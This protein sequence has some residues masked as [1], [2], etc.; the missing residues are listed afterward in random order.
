M[1]N[2]P[3]S[4]DN[5]FS[6]SDIHKVKFYAMLKKILL[7]ALFM[8]ASFGFAQDWAE[9]MTGTNAN[10]Y[11]IQSRFNDYWKDKDITE[12]GKGYKAFKRWENFVE[13]RVYPS[14]DL[15]LLNLTAKNFQEWLAEYN[16][17]NPSAKF[18]QNS[19]MAS[20]TWTPIGPMGA[21]SGSA[22]GQ[23]LKSGRLNFITFHPTN[24]NIMW[25]GA[26]AGG[27]WKTTDGGTTWS[28][29]TDNLA[30]NGCSDL[31]IDPSNTNIMYL[32][33]GDGDAGDTRS[34]GVL[35]STDGGNTWNSTGLTFAVTSNNLIRRLIIHP[36]NPQ[37]LLAATNSGIYRTTNGGTSW[38]NV[39][40]A[41]CY[42]LEFQP[43]NPNIV[44][45]GGTTF[46]RSTDGGVTWTQISNGITTTGVNRMAVA[47]TSNDANYVYVLCS[48]SSNS[49]FYGLYRS[50]DAGVTF[51]LMATTPNLLGWASAGNDSGGQ[52][53]YDLCVA[54]SPLDKNEV[55]VGGV[56]VWRS[57]NGGSTWTLYGHWTGSGA[58]FTHADHHDLEYTPAGV[59]YNCNDGT[60]YRRTATTWVEICGLMNISQIY[61]IGLSSLTPNLWITGHQDNGT[62]TWNGTTYQARIGGDG[63][64]CF[65]DRTNNNNIFGETQNGGFR[66]S[67]NAGS[68]WSTVTTG[69]SGT[70]PW[71]TIWKQDPVVANRIYCGRQNMFVSND[72][73]STWTQIGT[74]PV[75]GNVREFAIAPTNNQIIY[76]VKSNAIMKTTDGG[77]TWSNITGTLST[78]L[79]FFNLCVS[80]TDANKV[81]VC[82]TNYSA[83]NKV[84]YSSN[85]GTSWTNYSAN[86]PNIPANCLLYQ[87]GTSD[88]IYVGMD[89]GVYYRDNTQSTWTLY[90]NGLPNTPVD[91]MEISPA[92]PNTVV[93]ATYGRGVWIVDVAPAA[94][95]PVS[96][97]SYTG[98]VCQGTP[99]VF[100]DNSTNGPT[101]WVWSS[102]PSAGV[103]INTPTSQNPTITFANAGTYTISMQATNASG[104][105]NTHTQVVTVHPTPTITIASSANTVCAG[106]PVT[107]TA[108]GASTYSWA[109]PSSSICTYTAPATNTTY[110]FQGTSAQGCTGSGSKSI[111]VI[112]SPTVNINPASA[113]YCSNSGPVTLSASGATG[114]TWM[115]GSITGA[116]VSVSPSSNTTY[117]V[118]GT[119]G[120]CNNSKTITVTAGNVPNVNAT[121]S[122]SVYCTNATQPVILTASGATSYTWQPGNLTGTNASVTPASNTT[123]T[124]TGFNGSC[125]NTAQVSVN[126]QNP[127]AV[128][129]SSNNTL[130]CAGTSAILT[131]SGAT[132]YSWSTGATTPTITVFPTLSTTYT[133]IGFN[134][135][136]SAT[137]TI[138]QNVQWCTGISEKLFLNNYKVYPNPFSGALN[139]SAGE[140]VEVYITNALGQVLE[141]HRIEKQGR[142]NTE[143]LPS[144]I[145]FVNLKGAA[146]SRM[147]KLVKQ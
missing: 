51:S 41:N 86:L 53:W 29:N 74:L 58:P 115:P 17:A 129:A 77:A 52:G 139:I 132:S 36:T 75:T 98:N 121:A 128:T 67:T 117:T 15:S 78:S 112:P 54:A 144:G 61:K 23:L 35:K 110:V 131:A 21:I 146:G 33:T 18:S 44:Y 65:F 140:E 69:L 27:L 96:S 2:L 119:N 118:T 141:T 133:V 43:G 47:V 123:Y 76:V 85:G 62:S 142:V 91:D 5:V 13:P 48:A 106:S 97:Y 63:M 103:T 22:G 11:D 19:L 83:G 66:R 111:A 120:T 25:V 136:C 105:G 24:T 68:T 70:A 126:A 143:N 130:I 107:F 10:F 31:A 138:V 104:P 3:D 137:T 116:T 56:N 28:T 93:A 82:C 108:S 88:R 101:S 95:P 42:D 114:Y 71:V 102:N 7:G 79:S 45:A 4:I 8:A 147:F 64:D 100:N 57:T 14:G 127:P 145:Y 84:F 80:P 6:K 90:N 87:P 99:K 39:N 9:M 32:A 46:R 55:V 81:W 16:A 38:T 49:G 113:V 26:P 20:T 124:V 40:T 37:I 12:K 89:V 30:V 125:Y 60:V 109:C 135:P 92:M 134:G 1:L 94:L 50:I 72:L 73:A 59:L 122:N 34:I